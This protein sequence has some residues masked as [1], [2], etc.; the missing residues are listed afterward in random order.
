MRQR[1]APIVPR[2]VGVLITSRPAISQSGSF[3]RDA[4]LKREPFHN[5]KRKTPAVSHGRSHCGRLVAPQS[6]LAAGI[7]LAEFEFTGFELVPLRPANTWPWRA[8]R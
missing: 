5:A 1:V 4:D 3:T 2:T 7:T 6:L 8:L